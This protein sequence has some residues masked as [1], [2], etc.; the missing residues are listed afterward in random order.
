MSPTSSRSKNKPRKKPIFATFFQSGFLLGLF[1][2]PEDEGDMFLRNIGSLNR[3]SRRYIPGDTTLDDIGVSIHGR[4]GILIFVKALRNFLMP[5]HAPSG[6]VGLFPGAPRDTRLHVGLWRRDKTV[7]RLISWR[8]LSAA[9]RNNMVCLN[10][11]QVYPKFL[12]I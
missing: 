9:L 6:S 11:V 4:K 10:V 7:E 5:R 1:F 3:T 12:H 2:D 8:I